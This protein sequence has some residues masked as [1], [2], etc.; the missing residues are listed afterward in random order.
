M[1]QTDLILL[2]IEI[3]TILIAIMKISARLS[4]RITRIECKLEE[5]DEKLN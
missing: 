3:I 4:A 2:T 1:G 5:I